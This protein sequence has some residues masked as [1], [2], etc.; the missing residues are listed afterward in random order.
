[1]PSKAFGQL[2][3]ALQATELSVSLVATTLK[4]TDQNATDIVYEGAF[5]RAIV[6]FERFLEEYF[7]EIVTSAVVPNTHKVN[8]LAMFKTNDVAK[9]FI[10]VDKQYAEWLPYETTVKRAKR[11]I[12]DGLPFASLPE[13]DG[14]AIADAIIVRNYITHSSASARDKF[15]QQFYPPTRAPIAPSDAQLLRTP[16]KHAAKKCKLDG[17]MSTFINAAMFLDPP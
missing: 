1:M 16:L 17:F 8:L 4:S 13:T 2:H 15:V 9:S 12:E 5:L 6:A 7:V 10:V 14:N 3:S 11:F